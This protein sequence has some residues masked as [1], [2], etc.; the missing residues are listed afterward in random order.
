MENKNETTGTIKARLEILYKGVI[1][2]ENSVQY[3]ETLVEKTSGDS[4]EEIGK[5]RMYDE[6][7]QEELKHVEKF[8]S[9]IALWEN[10]LGKLTG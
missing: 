8:K 10:E 5:R 1:S 9:L 3:Y 4:E 2:E 6:L 7:R